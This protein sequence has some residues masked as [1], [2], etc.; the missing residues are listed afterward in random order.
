MLRCVLYIFWWAI[1]NIKKLAAHANVSTTTVSRAYNF[2]NMV[3]AE[4]HAQVLHAAQ[5]MS[6]LPNA[7]TRRLRTQQSRV[8]GVV[9]PTLLNPVFAECLVGIA[10]AVNQAGVSI[11]AMA[12]N[13]RL[14]QE[15]Q[16]VLQLIAANVDG[17]LPVVSNPAESLPLASIRARHL[18]YVL[19]L[20]VIPITPACRL[21]ANRPCAR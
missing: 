2:P 10:H 5:K 3:R 13:Y 4:S 7:N 14:E 6:Y 12:T 20:T 9:P 17:L 1:V 19:V 21:T 16:A 18:R 11:L 15:E 8:L